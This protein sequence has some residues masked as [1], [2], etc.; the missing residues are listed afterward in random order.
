MVGR[1]HITLSWPWPRPDRPDRQSRRQGPAAGGTD[2]ADELGME[3]V[4]PAAAL[5]RCLAQRP[6]IYI[7]VIYIYVKVK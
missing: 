2:A 6:V 7:Y 3:G 1:E 5:G 4:T